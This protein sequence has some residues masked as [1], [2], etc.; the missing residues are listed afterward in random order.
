MENYK[1]KKIHFIH[2][3]NLFI[4]DKSKVPIIYDKQAFITNKF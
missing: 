2:L 1:K 3:Y 4:N